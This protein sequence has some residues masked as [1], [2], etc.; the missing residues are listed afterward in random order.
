M[1]RLMK[2]PAT[3]LP[4]SNGLTKGAGS[5]RPLPCLALAVAFDESAEDGELEARPRETPR[6]V[7]LDPSPPD[8]IGVRRA[9][10]TVAEI[11]FD[12]T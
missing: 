2:V 5:V 9:G 6:R 1:W 4:P 10:V 11:P 7:P 12:G 8:T 3:G